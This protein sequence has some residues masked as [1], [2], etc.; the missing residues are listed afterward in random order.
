LSSSF[1]GRGAPYTNYTLSGIDNLSVTRGNHSLKFGVEFR[2]V[3][4]YNDQLGGT[5]YSFASPQAFLAN[6]PTTI[7][8]NGDLSALSPFTGL[9]GVAK[10]Q[11]MYYIG[12]AQD[13]WRIR[14][15][16]TLNLGLR[17]EYYSPLREA[18]NKDVFFSIPQ[19]NI[20][21]KYSGDWY[22]SS[23]KNFGPR[24]GIT[25]SPT[26]SNNKTVLRAGAG[27]FYGPGQTED[28]LQPEANDR[29]GTTLSAA[30]TP[31]LAYPL[32]T[33]SIYANYNINSPTLGYQ[34]RAYAPGY[35]IPERVLSYTFSLQQQFRDSTV[36]TVG[37][38][39]S[40]GRNLF[41]RSV[42]NLI[43]GLNV[44]PTTGVA[45]AIRQFGNRFAEIDYK[46]S[47]GTDNYN[48]LQ[49]GLNRRYS[50]GLTLGGQYT[51]GHS[52]GN[53]AGS[54]EANTVGNP[55]NFDA[56]HGNNNFDIRQSLNVDALYELPFGR[57]RR[58]GAS[59][60]R[61]LDYA[62]GGWQLGGVL[63]ARSGVPIDVLITRPDIAYVDN[64]TGLVYQS[65][66]VV[67]GQPVTTAVVNTPG[68]GSSRNVRRPN[69]VPGVQPILYH[70]GLAYVNPAAF[71]IPEPGT[72][73]NSARNSL[74]GPAI[75]QLDITLTKQFAISERLNLELRG[76][77]YNI[78]NR[79]N[80]AN[81]G[82]VRLNPGL[83]TAPGATG[84][85]PGQSFT[86]SLAGGNFGV[87]NSTVSNQIGLGTAR[88]FQL[89][90]RLTF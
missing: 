76:E 13:E 52:I 65:P 35:R 51:W 54:N 72:Y 81:P 49:I 9:S 47:G 82:N 79:A 14:P 40:Q 50:R 59:A 87:L 28:Q 85:Q 31:G 64:R 42:T 34:P 30:T 46:T 21:P 37:Y 25:W 5:T 27:Y 86:P 80:F 3:T 11:Q 55:F 23:T 61:A 39:G 36:L 58:F 12:Y 1:N 19:G 75:A 6:Q 17:Y 57:G 41:L 45:S 71:S 16:F 43:T 69:V 22:Q 4:L 68:G 44:N 29:I 48:A 8:F 38:V 66:V 7:A 89:A 2:P 63:N 70:S 56:D 84:I 67:N 60:P 15:D 53:S 77:C 74:A 33:A 88:Q 24:I 26:A 90:L 32:N 83:P 20:I 73:G 62:F 78:A 18:R 10:L